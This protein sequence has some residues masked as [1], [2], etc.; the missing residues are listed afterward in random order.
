ML[1]NFV[2]HLFIGD[3]G[4][5]CIVKGKRKFWTLYLIMHEVYCYKHLPRLCLNFNTE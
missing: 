4:V 3:N 5:P 1:Y 2:G